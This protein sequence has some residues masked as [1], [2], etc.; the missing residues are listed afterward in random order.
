MEN[1]CPRRIK[2]QL[3]P[4]QVH[5]FITFPM[6]MVVWGIAGC[7]ITSDVSRQPKLRLRLYGGWFMH[8]IND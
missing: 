2:I 8:R 4:N 3:R 5:V 6:K 1:K 7:L